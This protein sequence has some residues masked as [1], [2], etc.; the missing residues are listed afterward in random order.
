MFWL[1]ML[2]VNRRCFQFVSL[3]VSRFINLLDSALPHLVPAWDYSLGTFNHIKVSRPKVFN[4]SFMVC[5]QQQALTRAYAC[6]WL[7]CLFWFWIPV[8]IKTSSWYIPKYPVYFLWAT[9][10]I[11]KRLIQAFMIKR[12]LVCLFFVCFFITCVFWCPLEHKAV[13]AAVQAPLSPHHSVPER[14]GDQ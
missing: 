8:F 10:N 5:A 11:L 4:M 3:S 9:T 1:S 13:L 12:H 6:A 14:L 2:S 7:R